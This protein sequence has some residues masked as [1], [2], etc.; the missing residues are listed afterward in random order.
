VRTFLAQEGYETESDELIIR[1]EI[2]AK[3]TSRIF[4]NDSPASVHIIRRLGELI[5]DFHGQHDHQSLLRPELHLRLIDSVG[6][7]ESVLRDFRR[8]YDRWHAARQALAEHTERA[9]KLKAEEELRAF[10][11]RELEEIAP[12]ADEDEKLARELSKAENAEEL[13]AASAML[14]QM[15]YEADDSVRDKLVTARAVLDKLSGIDGEFTAWRA[16]LQ[17]AIVTVEE[18]ARFSQNYNASVEF[19]PAELEEMRRRLIIL[20]RLRKKYGSVGEAIQRWEA[21]REEHL[22]SETLESVEEKLRAELRESRTAMGAIGSKL[23]QKRKKVAGDIE[24]KILSMLAEL[25]IASASF[26]V[27][28]EQEPCGSDDWETPSALHKEGCVRAWPTGIDKAEFYIS[29]NAG[30]P[31]RPLAR[32]ASGGEISRIMLSLKTILAQSDRLPLLIFDEIDTGI[33][34][35]ISSKVG[36]AMKSLARYH[37]IIAI[38]HQPQIA[39]LADK[40]ILVEK[41]VRSNATFVSA[42]ILNDQDHVHEVARLLSGEDITPAALQSARDLIEG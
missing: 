29:T 33:S 4:V 20:G 40:H 9:R 25:G 31:A 17:A 2:S 19:Q 14:Y 22:C 42:H 12:Q 10:Q 38:T 27:H 18:I 24:S 37:Q 11:L 1:R 7:L 23:S 41:T 36:K 13:Y 6:G 21:L 35:R 3:R 28:F 30:E 26:N 8:E 34:G 32:T 39:A 16:E 5:L 15:L